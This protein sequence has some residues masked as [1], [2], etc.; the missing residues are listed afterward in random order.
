[1]GAAR[2]TVDAGQGERRTLTNVDYKF[3]D[4]RSRRSATTRPSPGVVGRTIMSRG[5]FVGC[6]WKIFL[7]SVPSIFVLWCFLSDSSRLENLTFAIF[8]EQTRSTI[9]ALFF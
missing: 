7:A 4:F 9:P 6:V 5:G 1:M 2:I 8:G 3:G